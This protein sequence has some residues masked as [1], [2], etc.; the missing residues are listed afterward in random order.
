MRKFENLQIYAD[1][2]RVKTQ[3]E[4]IELYDLTITSIHAKTEFKT[5]KPAE[6]NTVLK[7]FD[8]LDKK[9]FQD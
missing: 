6:L 4:P 9:R 2:Q 8:I 7:A 1:Y 3:G 5:L